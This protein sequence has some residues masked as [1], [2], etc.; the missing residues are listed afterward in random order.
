MI[1]RIQT[2]YLFSALV[3]TILL[4]FLPLAEIITVNNQLLLFK[5]S[6]LYDTEAGEIIIRTAPLIILIAVIT[7]LYFIA[8]FLFKRRVVQARVCMLNIL[9]HAGLTGLLIYYLTF[10]Y[11]K[12]EMSG[13]GIQLA[14]LFPVISMILTYMAYRSI[15]RDEKLV[16]S[17][18]TIR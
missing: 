17:A 9:L 13:S 7:F 6:G 11:R 10:I 4:F 2:L 3:L 14:V 12:V 5:S 18:D 15:H 1:Q 16:R 8:I